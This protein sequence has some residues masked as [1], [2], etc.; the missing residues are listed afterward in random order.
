[1]YIMFIN[2]NKYVKY[3]YQWVSLDFR[4]NLEHLVRDFIAY[5]KTKLAM[6]VKSCKMHRFCRKHSLRIVCSLEN[7]EARWKKGYSDFW[8]FK[9]LGWQ[10]R[11][12]SRLP[13]GLVKIWIFLLPPSKM[14]SYHVYQYRWE[15]EQ[16]R[17]E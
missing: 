13:W 9:C 17:T 2:T 14:D 3:T 8:S 10:G 16:H 1:M 6:S 15:R 11:W 4:T 7:L 5:G 12:C